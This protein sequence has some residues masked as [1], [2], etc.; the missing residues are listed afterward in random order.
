MLA[1]VAE[2]LLLVDTTC[3]LKRRLAVLREG[4]SPALLPLALP[5]LDQGLVQG[6]GPV[7]QGSRSARPPAK[8]GPDRLEPCSQIEIRR[9]LAWK[10]VDPVREEATA[11]AVPERSV[12]GS[13]ADG[14]LGVGRRQ[15]RPDVPS[16]FP[17]R[18]GGAT[19]LG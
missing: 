18:G 15:C 8:P 13:I 4:P 14:V 1:D 19:P 7:P 5:M 17:G 3:V 10:P 11:V 9:I 2:L 16:G 6:L 12:P